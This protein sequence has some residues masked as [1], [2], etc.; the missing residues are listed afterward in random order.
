MKAAP[1]PVVVI[2]QLGALMHQRGSAG[3]WRTPPR[4]EGLAGW[5]TAF[6]SAAGASRRSFTA[7]QNRKSASRCALL[8]ES[9]HHSI[10]W[11]AS[12]PNKSCAALA[13]ASGVLRA[14]SPQSSVTARAANVPQDTA[15]LAPAL[16]ATARGSGVAIDGLFISD[17][18]AGTSSPTCRP[19]HDAFAGKARFGRCRA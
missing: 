12:V 3:S 11:A 10:A 7:R 13:I 1:G 15:A 6:P 4:N 19:P 16:R 18:R 8:A 17:L 2:I 9:A 5:I 14:Q